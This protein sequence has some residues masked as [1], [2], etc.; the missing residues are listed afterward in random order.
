M[1]TIKSKANDAADKITVGIVAYSTA[2]ETLS[3]L[4]Q[5][6]KQSSCTLKIVILCNSPDE[7]Y[8]RNI[9]VLTKEHG[10]ELLGHEP[11]RGFGAGHNTIA[12]TFPSEW[13]ICCNPDV[14]V[15][16]DTI[17][18]LLRFAEE[19]SDAVLLMPRVMSPDGSVQ[20][21]ARRDLTP[22]S[23]LHRQLWRVRPDYFKPFELRFNYYKS[24]PVEFVTGCF[25]A[26]KQEHFWRLGGFDENFFLY[27]EDADLSYRAKRIGKN[28]FVASSVIVHMWTT[29]LKRNLKTIVRE[30]RSLIFYFNK[31]KL[32]FK[33][34]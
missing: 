6:L 10:I 32:W 4:I 21:L 12:R 24:Q 26:V 8:Q 2:H 17:I 22:I 31:H 18:E 25:F 16:P 9:K 15:R 28:Y 5:S 27:A 19:Q 11:N 13:Y 29:N 7:E 1:E 30:I 3:K 34:Y 23:W 20:P 33:A 14:I